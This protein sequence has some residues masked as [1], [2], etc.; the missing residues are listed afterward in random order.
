ML[1]QSEN[2]VSRLRD[3]FSS[4]F[5][6][7]NCAVDDSG[8]LRALFRIVTLMDEL[9]EKCVIVSHSSNVL[10]LLDAMFSAAEFQVFHCDKGAGRVERSKLLEKCANAS[11]SPNFR[12][13]VFLQI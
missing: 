12:R 10:S 1:F 13:T 6:L 3:S 5:S 9:G 8:K 2:D 7:N 4:G 11:S